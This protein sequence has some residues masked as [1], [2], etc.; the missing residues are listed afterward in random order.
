M[1][2]A[3]VISC[4]ANMQISVRCFGL[5]VGTGKVKLNRGRGKVSE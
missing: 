5:T 1:L 3:H 4:R 2:A